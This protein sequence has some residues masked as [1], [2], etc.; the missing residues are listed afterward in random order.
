M[1]QAT[2]IDV[3]TTRDAAPAQKRMYQAA[4]V[5]RLTA[6]WITSV[7]SANSE[8]LV[9]RKAVIARCRQLSRD[10][11]HFRKIL[12]LYR[13]NVIGH[14]GIR[15]QMRIQD[16]NGKLDRDACEMVKDAWEEAGRREH[17]TTTRSLSRVEVQGIAI[18]ALVR[19]GGML[20]RKRRAFANAFAYA[21][22]PIEIDRLD[23]DYNL[24]LGGSQNRVQFGIEYDE[25]EAPIAYHVLSRH[26]GDTFAYGSSPRYRERI[27]ADEIIPIW[28]PERAGQFVGMP[29]VTAILNRLNIL[30]KYDQ[31]EAVAAFIA[32]CK[33]GF[34]ITKTDSGNY[35]GE[36]DSQ[37]NTTTEM[38]PGMIEE[39]PVNMTYQANDPQHPTDAYP[40]F[41][42]KQLRDVASGAE[43][44]YHD[45]ANDL[46]GV[47][48]SSI[49]SGTLEARESYKTYQAIIIEQ[50]M[51]PWFE[52]W[53]PYAIL[54]KKISL[55]ISK[56]NKWN[57]P[58]WKPRRWPW[59]DPKNDVEADLLE[60]E[61][62]LTSRRRVI[63]ENDDGGDIE[64]IFQEQ[65]EDNALAELH[66]L[67]FS[68]EEANPPTVAPPPA[69][70]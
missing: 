69:K 70:K 13:N 11:P 8:I 41:T 29:L 66:K 15:L 49:R 9:S 56:L 38:Q 33:S 21:L 61:G 1:R 19:D 2:V 31:A 42:K 50:L 37:G 58:C 54:S 48:Y 14:K 57:A 32:S 26:P 20:F 3:K 12:S 44:P 39:L 51:T 5:N 68:G 53:L 67:D 47:N 18:C 17:C 28:T 36:K 55:P 23:H 65:E 6:D 24:P 46:E 4:I 59:V 52:D 60:I 34:L 40:A 64:E 7:T 63:A 16:A 10:N 43:V 27:P 45:L 30:D 25:F 35:E 22:E 62:G